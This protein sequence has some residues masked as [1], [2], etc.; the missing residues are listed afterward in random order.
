ME[1]TPKAYVPDLLPCRLPGLAPP[2]TIGP[3]KPHV[4]GVPLTPTV[5]SCQGNACQVFGAPS[6]PTVGD[7]S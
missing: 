2:G 1:L 7:P 3:P 4:L 6:T 5:A